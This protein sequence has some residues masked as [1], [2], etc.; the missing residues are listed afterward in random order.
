MRKKDI[1]PRKCK[2]RTLPGSTINIR[3]PKIHVK[4]IL[5][6]RDSLLELPLTEKE[7]QLQERIEYRR[8]KNREKARK[9]RAR[10]LARASQDNS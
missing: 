5:A 8:V 7:K 9:H 2:M 6:F 1:T 4:A 3:V 10:V